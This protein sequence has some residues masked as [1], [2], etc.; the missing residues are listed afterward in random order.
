M[1]AP[2]NGDRQ[3]LRGLTLTVLI[4]CLLFSA[5]LAGWITYSSLY[6]VIL[7]DGFEQK[8]VAVSTGVAALADPEVHVDLSRPAV[9]VGLAGDPDRPV[10]WGV[11]AAEGRLVSIDLAEGS[12]RPAGGPALDGVVG[13]AWH[14]PSGRLLTTR[15]ATGELLAFTT[16][17]DTLE[18]AGR[19]A[20]GAFALALDSTGTRLA[21]AGPWGLRGYRYEAA[22]SSVEPLWTRDV[23]L[24]GVTISARTGAVVA[25]GLDGTLMVA[26][27]FGAPLRALGTLAP[28]DEEARSVD[29]TAVRALG[30]TPVQAGVFA[31]GRR[32]MTLSPGD[33]DFSV[34]AFRRGYRDQG[35]AA[36][37][38]NVE[39]LRRIRTALD[40][41]YLYTQN[42]VPG[43]S[44][45]YV[46]D[47]TP[48][49]DDHSPIGTREAL[50]TEADIRG[51]ADVMD[52]GRVYSSGIE[53]SE[54]WG[55]LKSAYAPIVGADDEPVGMV[56]TDISVSTIQDR[57]QIAL[58]KVGLVTVVVLFLGALGSVAISL[59][60]T[61]PLAAV[62]EG[63][64]RVAAGRLGEPIEPPRLRDLAA[65]TTS[66]NEM[67]Q[68]LK[69]TVEELEEE[70]RRVEGMRIRRHLTRELDRV[71]DDGVDLPPGLSLDVGAEPGP[72]PA[73]VVGVRAGGRRLAVV[74]LRHDQAD[75]F[76]ALSE[77]AELQALAGR[78]VERVDGRPAELFEALLRY[79]GT[80]GGTLLVVEPAD[81]TVHASG[82]GGTDAVFRRVRGRDEPVHLAADGA[83][84]V[85]ADAELLVR[86]RAPAT[87]SGAGDAASPI[88]AG[89]TSET[90]PWT[91]RLGRVAE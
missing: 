18:V 77:R 33:L 72:A 19:I 34:E 6:G 91:L 88:A 80:D 83:F 56:G 78:L 43:D 42:L 23:A 20:P 81:R 39:P 37:A 26:D 21:A 31:A 61:G 79:W 52:R 4:P 47:G 84:R 51:L 5:A 64:S 44:I 15:P 48:L 67:T 58:A 85:P 10:L 89:E 53:D 49:G 3:S 70:S 30:S 40:V 87:G 71:V 9:V 57:T 90:E 2:S 27:T 66:F 7:N 22:T 50:E 35:G 28:G 74:W 60:L 54:E 13:L 63:A 24:R 41:T 59:R 16:A 32:L 86:A 36:Y 65:L 68:T 45:Q 12:A 29:L 73:D 38:V 17:S 8:L 55:L 11:D 25:L 69:T 82:D 75:A 14:V 62:Q 46:L 76:R 1:S